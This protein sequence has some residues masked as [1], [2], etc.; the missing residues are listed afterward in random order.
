MS[1]NLSAQESSLDSNE[2]DQPDYSRNFS[3]EEGQE[4]PRSAS[5][6]QYLSDIENVLSSDDFAQR[7]T[8][9]RWRVKQLDDDEKEARR[10]KYPEWMIEFMEAFETGDSSVIAMSKGVELLLWALLVGLLIVF[11]IRYRQQLGGVI[12]R[13]NRKP[14]APELPSNMF[15][16][17]IKQESLPEDV[18]DAARSN[19]AAGQHREAVAVLLRASLLNLIVEH[20][21]RFYDSDT[22]SECCDRIDQQASEAVSLYMRKLVSVWQ[23]IAYAHITPSALLFDELCQQWRKVF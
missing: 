3:L 22:E 18:V 10:E 20:Q 23:S 17:D 2:A 9:E 6:K 11:I 7:K 16:L 21:C 19:W 4:L 12:D 5:S 14:D 13:F 15:G 1:C 8:V